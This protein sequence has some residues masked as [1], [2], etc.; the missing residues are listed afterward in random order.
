MGHKAYFP[1]L[2]A[3]CPFVI[4]EVHWIIGCRMADYILGQGRA[5]FFGLRAEIGKINDKILPRANQNLW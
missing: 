5:T 4:H 1:F 2:N 3:S